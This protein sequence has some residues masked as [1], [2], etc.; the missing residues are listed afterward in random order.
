LSIS[1]FFKSLFTHTKEEAAHRLALRN[2]IYESDIADERRI[3]GRIDIAF[4]GDCE[5]FAFTL[6]IQIGGDVW[7]V[8]LPD[9]QAHAVLVI[10]DKCYC[11]RYRRPVSR[12]RYAGKF[13][14]IMEK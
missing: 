13:L 2:F 14:F 7:Y 8:L 9:G 5:D 11:N 6:K 10:G 3:Y 4:R 12:K 1:K